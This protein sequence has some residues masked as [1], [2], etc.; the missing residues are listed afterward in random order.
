MLEAADPARHAGL[1]PGRAQSVRPLPGLRPQPLAQQPDLGRGR[2]GRGCRRSR[3]D[4]RRGHDPRGPRLALDAP[5]RRVPGQHGQAVGRGNGDPGSGP[6][7]HGRPRQQGRRPEDRP[8]GPPGRL[9][10]LARRSFRRAGHRLRRTDDPRPADRHQPRRPGH[11]LLPRRDHRRLPGQHAQRRR[12]RP[13][14]LVRAGRGAG[15]RAGRDHP[16]PRQRLRPGDHAGR[17][18]GPHPAAGARPGPRHRPDQAG[19]R[20]PTAAFATSP[21][22]TAPSPAR[23]AWRWRPSTA[24]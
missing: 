2:R 11:R 24:A 15:H 12:H 20:D 10:D 22:A 19:H 9:H 17:D 1:R 14:E 6:G 7:G 5:G 18:R 4:R 13:E 16:L 23:A 8:P 21:S 3:S